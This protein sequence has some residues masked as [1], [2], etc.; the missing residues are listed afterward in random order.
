LKAIEENEMYTATLSIDHVLGATAVPLATEM[1][2]RALIEAAFVQLQTDSQPDPFY[3]NIE[4]YGYDHFQ[5]VTTYLG[6]FIVSI[7]NS[8]TT[9]ANG[10]DNYWE[11]LINGK[12]ADVG[13]DSLLVKPNDQIVL[14]WMAA[15]GSSSAAARFHR[16]RA[17]RPGGNRRS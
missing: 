7:G 3:F 11:L 17:R 5:G 4:Y 10:S 13:M 12:P 14:K 6:Y 2:V 16:A 1:S 9:Y 15:T 8:K